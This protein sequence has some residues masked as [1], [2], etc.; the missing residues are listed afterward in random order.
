MAPGVNPEAALDR[1]GFAQADLIWS[2][3]LSQVAVARLNGGDP[4]RLYLA[5]ALLVSG[6]GVP[7]GCFNW[8]RV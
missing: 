2:D 6:S 8:A 5:G 4:W 3:P 7:A 1:A